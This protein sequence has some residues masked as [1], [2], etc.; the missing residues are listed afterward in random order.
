MNAVKTLEKYGMLSGA[1]RVLCALSG[2]PDSVALTHF[3]A[4]NASALGVKVYA[5]HFSHGIRPEAA[6]P[7]REICEK[8]C[9][10]L[11]IEL[12]CGEG[13][14]PG[15]AKEKGV[16]LELAARELRYA[17]LY[18]TAEMLGGAL[19]AT[20]HHLTD[21][22]ETVLMNLIRGTSL[23]GLSGIPPVRDGIIRPF[24]ETP[25]EEIDEYI[26]KN[27]L[28]FATDATNFEPCCRRNAIRLNVLPLL[29]GEEPAA[30]K[31]IGRLSEIARS[32][33]AEAEREAEE[34]LL[35]SFEKDGRTYIAVSDVL[36]LRGDARARLFTR[37]HKK[38]GGVSMLSE[39][40]IKAL[41]ALCES[42]SPSGAADLPQISA[43]REYGSLVFGAV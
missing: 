12:F 8:L 5:A 29:T 28:K 1:K 3:M 6:K 2:G 33:T 31:N 14:A 27:G 39:K 35:K 34:A 7:E 32:L 4:K 30:I 25:K 20:A 23:K 42:D 43:K 17:F 38:A 41:T 11:G 37:L 36:S 26:E 13:D 19:I 9:E 10:N 22:A 18:D 15:Y 16:G 40:H 24:I 21:N